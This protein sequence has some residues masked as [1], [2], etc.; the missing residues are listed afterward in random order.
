MANEKNLIPLNQRTKEQQREIQSAGGKARAERARERKAMKETAETV[1]SMPMGKGKVKSIEDIKSYLELKG[2]NL[3]VQET[4]ILKQVE[5][6]IKG[7]L[8][9]AEF[10]RDLVGEKP[11]A[12][13]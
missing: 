8:K 1:L 2:K 5:K 4:I 9:A 12:E 3:T 13:W 7:D 6:A 10:L 11:L